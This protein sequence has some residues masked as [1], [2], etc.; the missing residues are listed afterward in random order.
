MHGELTTAS[1]EANPW[2]TTTT[3]APFC[4]G[5]KRHAN[6]PRTRTKNSL[7]KESDG[8]ADMNLVRLWN[9]LVDCGAEYRIHK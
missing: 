1:Y 5:R 2:C 9:R 6:R 3:F 8:E 4:N 7:L